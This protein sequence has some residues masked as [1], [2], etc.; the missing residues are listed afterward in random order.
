[1]MS[2]TLPAHAYSTTPWG[3]VEAPDHSIEAHGSFTWYNRSVGTTG[4]VSY[5]AVDPSKVPN[6]A[7]VRFDYYQAD[8][9]LSSARRSACLNGQRSRSTGFNFT[10]L[11]PHGGITVIWVCVGV[12]TS[13]GD[14]DKACSNS[15]Y[16]RPSADD[17][18]V[19]DLPALPDVEQTV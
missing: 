12:Q 17:G 1:M 6:C 16:A 13:S 3:P 8:V 15:A 10:Q 9:Y 7:Y 4:T 5:A 19:P 11:G 14:V 2:A 18:T